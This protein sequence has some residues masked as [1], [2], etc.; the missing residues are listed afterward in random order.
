MKKSIGFYLAALACVLS[1]VGVVLYTRVPLTDML[2]YVMLACGVVAG[3]LALIL[4]GKH[5]G[6]TADF[7]VAAGTVLVAVGLSLSVHPVVLD[8]SSAISGLSTWDILQEYFVFAAV[9]GVAWL[10]FLIGAF[11]GVG[12]EA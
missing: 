6:K 2:V 4:N 11:T 3:V 5:Y 10:M 9:T 12:K 1:L 7:L 8:F